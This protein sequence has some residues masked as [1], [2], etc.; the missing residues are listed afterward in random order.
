MREVSGGKS[1]KI[2]CLMG[3]DQ[4][5]NN[6]FLATL[7]VVLLAIAGSAVAQ[8]QEYIYSTDLG[9][10]WDQSNPNGAGPMDCGDIY[11]ENPGNNTAILYKDD[12][13]PTQ[14]WTGWPYNTAPQPTPA[15]IGTSPVDE[16]SFYF[17]LD[18]EDQ[19][20]IDVMVGQPNELIGGPMEY[21]QKGLT[22][23]PGV[24]HVSYDD[25]GPN[26]WAV[27]GDVPVTALPDDA[28]EIYETP[29]NLSPPPT[30]VGMGTMVRD[31]F[32]LGLGQNP[33]TQDHD[34]DVDALDW[35][36]PLHPFDVPF[37][38]RYW[39]PDHEA[40]M[41][42]DPGGIYLTI[43][44][45]GLNQSQ[46]INEPDL[47]IILSQEADVDAFEFIAINEETY[48]ELFDPRPLVGV[49]YL[50]I[51]FSVDQDDLDTPNVDESGG[52]NPNTIYI[53]NL[54]GQSVA[55]Q[56]HDA[57]VDAITVPEPTTMSLLAIAGLLAI[58]RRRK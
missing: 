6:A 8:Q 44:G 48:N 4:M 17:D 19:L 52:W 13:G 34:D 35:H 30:N 3:E 58:R 57:D 45:A 50:V 5:R 51:L 1:R 32:M 12:T 10:Q 27:S 21:A 40:N 31:E 24:V 14:W 11:L 25:D 22:Y 7:V 54:A 28:I 9:S 18:G 43:N 55:L 42:N 20:D 41:G 53:S 23:M 33:P 16:Y 39:S 46:V 36:G 2:S 37:T 56:T 15:M 26:G 49:D 29:L 38:N 47:D